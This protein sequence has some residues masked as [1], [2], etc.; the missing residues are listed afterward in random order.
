MGQLKGEKYQNAITSINNLYIGMKYDECTTLSSD[1]QL[2]VA[3][4]ITEYYSGFKSEEVHTREYYRIITS[5]NY[6]AKI[7]SLLA[8]CQHVLDELRRIDQLKVFSDSESSEH[9]SVFGGISA[10]LKH[11][12]EIKINIAFEKINYEICKCGTKMTPVPELSELHCSGCPKI[13]HISGVVFRDDQFY[14][15][16]G[17]KT[18]HGGYDGERH[19]KFWAERIQ[20]RENKVFPDPVLTKIQHVIDRETID[21]LSLSVRSMRKILKDL[22]LTKYN[23]H[24]ALLVVLFGGPVPPRLDFQEDK[25]MYNRFRKCMVLYDLAVPDGGNKPYYPYFIFKG[26][27]DLFRDNPDKLRLL[28]FIHLQSRE[29]IVKNDIT[30]KRM[31][32]IAVEMA[33]TDDEREKTRK[34]FVYRPTDPSGRI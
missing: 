34:E 15:Q 29:T 24:A 30:Y 12:A 31:C 16:D 33:A 20:A 17:Q 26:I 10:D 18:K 28:D 6:I 5:N 7:N 21:K 13:K 14:P 32:E 4:V 1:Y 23:D 27:E 8:V 25:K 3:T 9:I 19:Y 2:E 11:A 22:K